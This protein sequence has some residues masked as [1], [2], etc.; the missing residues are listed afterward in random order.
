MKNIFLLIFI[1]INLSFSATYHRYVDTDSS[2]NGPGTNSNY[3]SPYN[4]LDS[5][6]HKEISTPG[7]N[8][9][10]I[11]HCRG[12]TADSKVTIPKAY[13]S[14]CRIKIMVDTAYRHKGMYSTDKY[15][16]S[17]STGKAL[18]DSAKFIC[19]EGLQIVVTGTGNTKQGINLEECYG[20]YD[21]HGCIL[22]G[23]YTGYF[24]YGVWGGTK[25]ST[26]G[27]LVYN[28]IVYDFGF[29]SAYPSYYGGLALD[30]NFSGTILVANNTFFNCGQGI[31]Y[32]SNTNKIK[33]I[34]NIFYNCID[35]VVGTYLNGSDYNATDSSTMSYTVTG[36]GNT[37][38]RV[39]QNFSFKNIANDT[40]IL[41]SNDTAA[42]DKGL[43]DPGNFSIDIIGTPRPYNTYWDIGAFEYSSG[44]LSPIIVHPSIRIDTVKVKD[45]IQLALSG[46]TCDSVTGISLPAWMA[47]DKTGANMG[48]VI[49]N[50]TDSVSQ[51]G[52]R[53]VAW[54]CSNDTAIC[55]TTV[56]WGNIHLNTFLPDTAF[57]GDTITILGR[58]FKSSQGTSTLAWGDSTPAIVLWKNDTIKTVCPNTD[59]GHYIFIVCN[60]SMCD[61]MPDSIYVNR[62]FIPII[63]SIRPYMPSILMAAQK[64]GAPFKIRG[65]GFKATQG[66]G[67]TYLGSSDL[68][69][70]AY[71]SDTLIIDTIPGGWTPK[72]VYNLIVKNSDNQ[73]DTSQIRVLIPTIT[74][75][76]P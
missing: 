58:G 31:M 65:R 76:T 24:T 60:G 72:G 12:A 33:L 21:I 61:T 47:L 35:P 63:D 2:T 42:R 7:L 39:N 1:I 43:N 74:R 32:S 18:V 10:I 6:I 14:T 51:T 73:R 11:F 44:C 57:V 68:L 15:R 53:F 49:L 45:T 38:D 59:T 66:T 34:N 70:A 3:S 30:C 22:K 28:N 50:P 55:T 27:D 69:T 26:S 8:D 25:T 52:Y 4:K 54:G 75:M 36:G 5:A 67:T 48:R 23:P 9:S 37:H 40:C 41:N 17:V 29:D 16:I 19:I 62:N 46:G 56:T 13:D 20:T 71:W 64:R